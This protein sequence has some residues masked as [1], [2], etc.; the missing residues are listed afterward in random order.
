MVEGRV[1]ASVVIPAFD[2]R[3]H[4][5][6]GLLAR[7]IA[8]AVGPLGLQG[9]EEA[10][11]Q[12]VV[13]AASHPAHRPQDAS[14]SA[15]LPEGHRGVLAPSIGMMHD[16]AGLTSLHRLI[17]GVEHESGPAMCLHRPA[18]YAPTAEVDHYC[19][20]QHALCGRDLRDVGHPYL[21]GAEAVKSCW[22]RSG[23]GSATGGRGWGGPGR[24]RR[25]TPC[26]PAARISRAARL[27]LINTPA[28]RSAARTR[29]AP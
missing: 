18:D 9:S 25:L 2:E 19:E 4:G 22:T 27:R 20:V 6:T 13:I 26:R 24:L 7:P 29:G 21:G 14:L 5:Q 28:A 3:E 15:P 23:A 1:Q 11:A 12:G 17:E 10:L 8:E 16:L